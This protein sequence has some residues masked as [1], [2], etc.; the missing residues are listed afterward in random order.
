[1]FRGSPSK[2]PKGGHKEVQ[3]HGPICLETDV[4]T[5]SLPGRYKHA[6]AT[7][8]SQVMKFQTK[9]NCNILWQQ[10]VL[11]MMKSESDDEVTEKERKKRSLTL[12]K[13]V[14]LLKPLRRMFKKNKKKRRSSSSPQTTTTTTTTTKLK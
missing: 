10:D 4:E 3:I 13:D 11:D 2:C 14:L 5:L 8:K 12:F 6:S 9:T 7:L 1:M